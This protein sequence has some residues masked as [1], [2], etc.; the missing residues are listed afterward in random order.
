MKLFKYNTDKSF[1][2]LVKIFEQVPVEELQSIFTSSKYFQHVDFTDI[3]GKSG[4][5]AVLS[6]TYQS[7]IEDFL[8]K[9]EIYFEKVDISKDVFYDN[10]IDYTFIDNS[11][12][13][14]VV[15]F[16][17]FFKE[18]YITSDDILDKIIE[19]GV[20]SLSEFDKYILDK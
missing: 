4:F 1:T 13:S 2:E 14:D 9:C 16:I 8:S 17:Q 20:D 6:D 10:Q 19:K 3:N 5:F 15:T 18:N 7:K 12:L 11:N